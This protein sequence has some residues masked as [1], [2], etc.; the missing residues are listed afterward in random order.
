MKKIAKVTSV[1]LSLLI[2][3]S[4][5]TV[6]ASAEGESYLTIRNLGNYATVI[7]CL[8]YATG[9]V[10]IP[11]TYDGVKV[12]HISSEA[13][14]DCTRITKVNIPSSVTQ[15]A[16]SAFDNCDSLESVNFAGDSC[17]IDEGAFANC[18]SLK[19]I[20]LPADITQLPERIFYGCTSLTEIE[21]PSK[22]TLIGAYAFGVCNQL[23]KLQ[24]PT[25]VKTIEKN[26]LVGC[27]KLEGITVESGNTVY[28]SADGVLYGPSYNGDGKALIQ[29][30]NAKTDE[31]YT[32][33]ADTK[34]ISDYAFGDNSYIKKII[35]PAGL[36]FIDSYA[37]YN[38][39]NLSD[40]KIPAGV[41][42]LGSQSFGRS[43]SL[44][45]ITI[46][47]SVE[48]FES[49]FYMS[50]IESVV[51]ENG[52]KTI[53]IRSFEK[54]ESLKSVTIPESV[55]KIGICAFLDCTALEKLNLSS[56]VT[57]IGAGAFTNCTKLTLVVDD[58]SAAL[59]YAIENS[60]PYE[61]NKTDPTVKTITG[62]SIQTPPKK[63]SYYYKESL[64]TSGLTIRV[65]YSDHPSEIISEGLD[66]E[67]R[68][69]N[70]TGS[71]PID[72]EYQGFSTTF[73]V[74][75]SYAWW[76]WIIMILLLGFLWY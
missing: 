69:F 4:C 51:I 76:Q 16:H 46:P 37:F 73:R 1:I 5:V 32:V 44:K 35:L 74:S 68:T 52:V 27:Y 33:A 63:V 57:N 40:I 75:V 10:D 36:T 11:E 49:A 6:F 62:I 9:V 13:F 42:E 71:F 41:K 22:V 64:N 38:C 67:P 31:T 20:N 14:K 34:V 39:K 3:F 23:E 12:T 43:A 53:G 60:I 61:V 56:K 45:S 29:Y 54:C 28:S 24:I 48:T 25:S 66:V 21:I 70:E 2:A 30:P 58:K 17:F 65:D 26:A 50:G 19:N 72:V 18:R 47:S 15:I 8:S 55:N 59:D 7:K